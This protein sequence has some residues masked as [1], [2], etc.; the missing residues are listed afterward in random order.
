MNAKQKAGLLALLAVFFSSGP[1]MSQDDGDQDK[2]I[3]EEIVVVGFKGSIQRAIDAKE[4]ADGVTDAI[5]AEDI[6]KSADQDIG[7]ALQRI[8]GVSISRGGGHGP[9]SNEEGTTV[10]VRGAGPNLN[11]ISLNGI[12]L[13]SSTENQ[14]VDLSAYS[15]DILNSI[16]VYKTATADQDE[17]SL[18]GSVLLRTFRPL[19]T[20]DVRR[21]LE[22][23]GRYDDYT[24]D[25]DHKFT[26]SFSQKFLDDT[27]GFYITAF[28]ETQAQRKDQFNVSSIRTQTA[29]NAIDAD[30][31]L[32]T[33]EV[34]GLVYDSP[35]YS[36]FLN[37]M[38]RE[39]FTTSLQWKLADATELNFSA[40][41]SN[42]YRVTQDNGFFALGSSEPWNDEDP[43]LED[44]WYVFD[45]DS[46]V[47]TKKI[48]R[49]NRGRLNQ[50][51]S[52]VET[53]NTIY[54]LTL[55]HAFS[56]RFSMSLSGGYSETTADDD[57][58]YRLNSNNYVHVSVE[59]LMAVP[60]DQ[61]Q[62]VGYDCTSGICLIRWG[63]DVVDFGPGQTG[64]P[65]E[66]NND[67]TVRTSFNPDDLDAVHLQQAVSRDRTMN[68]K[69]HSLYADF[70]WDV[71]FGPITTIEFGAKYQSRD[72]DVFNQEYWF[73]GI[74]API[75]QDNVG[76]GV[77]SVRL[78]QVTDGQTPHGG[79]FLSDLGYGRDNAT[80]GW[81]TL[82]ARE[83]F[84]LLFANPDNVRL[85]PNLANDR[86]IEL[87]N[88]AA[89]LKVNF[90]L[91]D[92][93]L[94][95]NIGVR[96]VE[97]DVDSVGYSSIIWQNFNLIDHFLVVNAL[98]DSLPACTPAQLDPTV[99]AGA[100]IDGVWQQ[101][102]A[103][104]CYDPAFDTNAN[105]RVRYEN[106]ARPEDPPQFQS[107]ATNTERNVLPS[108]TL[109][110][111]LTDNMIGRFAVSRTMAR[112]RI[113]SLKPG[114]TMREFPWG[115]G[116]SLGTL[117][118]PFLVPLE[119]DNIDL[120]YEWYFANGGLFSV[121][122]FHKDIK[123]FEESASV[124][125]HWAASF[126]DWPDEQYTTLDT[127]AILD[128]VFIPKHDDGTAR[129]VDEVDCLPNNRHR[130]Q[131][132]DP[133]I[134]RVCD[135]W[136]LVLV[137]NGKGGTNKGVEL[138]Y[139]QNYDFLPGVFSGL[140]M[141]LNYTYS[142]SETEAELIPGNT[143]LPAFPMENVSKHTYNA[144]LFWERDG[145]LVRLAYNH[146][147]DS[148][149]RRSWQQGAIWNDGGGRLDLSANYQFNDYTTFTF[150]AVNL[151][152]QIHRQYYTNYQD[153]RLP[154][155]GNPLDGGA[156]QSK[157]V[158]RWATGTQYRLGVR[159]SF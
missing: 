110:Y 148:L 5:F 123:T 86:Q 4:M 37:S 150:N 46:R 36:L 9:N 97:S 102:P 69:Q 10:T 139:S 146:R 154:I 51:Q 85:Q 127:A 122:L 35:G 144:S 13:T 117:N 108:L 6:G 145:S 22:L 91:L 138:G 104:L 109:N 114:F 55:D 52:A 71:D 59:T 135:T 153:D 44:A 131:S 64:A 12:S 158:R 151:T 82:N 17:G 105:T 47:F 112:P 49:L 80:D 68:D 66:S 63:T 121:A 70:D 89:Y 32:P 78:S 120:S 53:D 65:G 99:R 106:R 72:K 95:G 48:D 147:S 1:A 18:G 140:G 15:S 25:N 152:N 60:A 81:W 58:F 96:Y 83:A 24:E 136:N 38:D 7:E 130:W 149:A 28:S 75:G 90:S 141:T 84:G 40:T 74:P 67:N 56:D 92:D 54:G 21:V 142:D 43:I 103:Q 128:Q 57:Y 73:E 29:Q 11:N 31:G 14:A 19:D 23:Q 41:M 26:G 93:R 119:S 159:V 143:E 100:I 133:S 88:Q 34:T 20:D 134:S 137:R 126:R 129:T 2:D 3:K 115:S 98:D 76:L 125:G 94:R 155:E 27:L 101:D 61:V 79:D 118:N 124:S 77:D 157:T 16:Q 156:D 50:V 132:V 107:E 113:D 42:Q 116:N 45:T 30:T 39:G 62:P 33:G 111:M 8:T 87:T